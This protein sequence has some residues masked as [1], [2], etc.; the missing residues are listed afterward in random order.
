MLLKESKE[1][2]GESQE[3]K[4]EENIAKTGG[5]PTNLKRSIST[6]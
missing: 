1:L 2:S 3:G 5:K 6:F 4:S